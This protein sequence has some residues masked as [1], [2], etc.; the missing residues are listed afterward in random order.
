[1]FR[2][3][4]ARNAV[5]PLTVLFISVGIDL[6]GVFLTPSMRAEPALNTAFPLPGPR[7][8]PPSYRAGALVFLGQP[9]ASHASHQTVIKN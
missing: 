6:R 1:M 8:Y 3:G 7:R 9:G 4:F 2:R 5:L